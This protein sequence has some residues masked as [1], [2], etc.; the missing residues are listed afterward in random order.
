M[1][2]ETVSF[3]VQFIETTPALTSVMITLYGF[4]AMIE[5]SP[6][7]YVTDPNGNPSYLNRI[8]DT[9]KQT[10]EIVPD[11]TMIPG[12]EHVV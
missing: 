1:N 4:Q 2:G 5:T 8:F 10:F 3:D 6:D 7:V 11:N 9:D 12:Y